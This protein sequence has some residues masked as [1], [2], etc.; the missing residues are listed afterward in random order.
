MAANLQVVISC[1]RLEV[2]YKK[3]KPGKRTVRSYA[4]FHVCER[5]KKDENTRYMEACRN[6][7]EEIGKINGISDKNGR[8]NIINIS[9]YG[10]ILEADEGCIRRLIITVHW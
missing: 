7:P 5:L 8:N 1:V 4:Y 3:Y 9:Q 10:I 6:N 2:I